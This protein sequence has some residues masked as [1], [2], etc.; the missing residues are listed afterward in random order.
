MASS[1]YGDRESR[2]A[3]QRLC[4]YPVYWHTE[5]TFGNRLKAWVRPAHSAAP[6]RERAAPWD[7]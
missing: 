7:P 2:P 1:A 6:R 4:E 5:G 3:Q